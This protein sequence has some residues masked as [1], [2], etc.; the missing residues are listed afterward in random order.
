VCTPSTE[1]TGLLLKWRHGDEGAYERLIPLVHQ[2]LYLI[3]QRHMAHEGIGHTLQATALVNEAYLRLVDTKNVTWSDRTHFLAVAAR[4]MRHILV[5]H[6]RGR[7][8]QKRGGDATRAPFDEALVVTSEP[9]QDFVALHEALESLANVDER[10][11]QVVEL[12][13]FGGLTADETAAVLNISADTVLR[14]WQLAKAW[15]RRELR[16][17][18]SDDA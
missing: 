11:S 14:D 13:F 5:D 16:R 18:G 7:R 9:V 12:R 2:E 6:A 10:K 1:V 17:E 15:L 8:Y 4:V 3:A